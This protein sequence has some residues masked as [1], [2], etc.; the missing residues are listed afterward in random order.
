[1]NVTSKINV[2]YITTII[3]IPIKINPNFLLKLVLQFYAGS[4]PVVA[5]F[6]EGAM[7]VH[8]QLKPLEQALT[9][10]KT[11]RQIT[12]PIAAD[13]RTSRD[14]QSQTAP[15]IVPKRLITQSET[16]HFIGKTVELGT[17]I[18]ETG[19]GEQNAQSA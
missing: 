19:G 15:V 18:A 17:K 13:I 16:G 3:P 6:L 8:L 11:N 7:R 5:G 10:F 2:N 1:M 14:F 4:K 9:E 12:D